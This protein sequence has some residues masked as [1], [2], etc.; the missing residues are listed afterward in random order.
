MICE[1][2]ARP[3]YN[4]ASRAYTRLEHIYD[5][6]KPS[7]QQIFTENWE[8]FL[9][10]P[11]VLRKGLR[12]IVVQEV[13]KMMDCGTLA[14]GYE[15]YE[16]PNCHRSHIICYTCKSR[17][18]PSCSVKYAKQRAANV[19]SHTLDVDHRH[20]V[21]T[22]DDRLR[23]WFKEDRHMLNFLFDSAWKTIM[24][25]FKKNCRKDD[26]FT[27]GVMIT[28]HTFGRSLIWNPHVHCLVTEGG[29]NKKHIYKHISYINYEVLRKSFMR[30]LIKEMREYIATAH[31]EK[32][33]D[34]KM[35]ASQ[36]YSEH[37][38]GF[39]VNAPKMKE[40]RGKDAVVSYIVRYTCRPVMASS[41]ITEYDWKNGTVTYW[42]E[43]HKTNDHI[44]VKEPVFT[45]MKKLIQHIPEAQFKMIRYYGIYATCAHHH[46][47][48][49][50]T[51]ILEHG[52]HWADAPKHYRRDLIDTYGVDPLKCE[53]G[54]Y[55]VYID[56]Y[57]PSK[58]AQFYETG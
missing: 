41:R 34:F 36:M 5:P 32:L 7:I 17:F 48:K 28:L 1:S 11:E 39:Y 20:I 13:Q 56:N 51:L 31:P 40:K 2:W 30:T 3:L 21:F 29:M 50:K 45:F 4:I 6:K 8:D 44:T 19:S 18:C 27:P 25:S 38:N 52:H 54:S 43:D 24:Y 16:C 35:L 55:M 22:I 42:Y 33:K 10:D 49:V 58:G 14:A 23:Q 37:E 47:K 9:S 57:I 15:I 46:K 26:T 12:P 53:C